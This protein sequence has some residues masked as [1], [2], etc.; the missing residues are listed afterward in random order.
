MGEGF[1]AGEEGASDR[2]QQRL[3]LALR[4]GGEQ[5]VVGPRGCYRASLV[6][7][8]D[9]VKYVDVPWHLRPDIIVELRAYARDEGS[10]FPVHI[11]V[12][13]QVLE[14]KP[15]RPGIRR[16]LIRVVAVRVTV[17][18]GDGWDDASFSHDEGVYK[19]R[20]LRETRDTGGAHR[21]AVRSHPDVELRP[22]KGFPLAVLH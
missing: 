20:P 8:V 21:A 4:G 17:Q 15:H 2:S 9:V 14:P 1:G 11:I 22:Q 13:G 19:D 18:V 12:E 6:Q 16:G 10:L 5:L 7:F 3:E